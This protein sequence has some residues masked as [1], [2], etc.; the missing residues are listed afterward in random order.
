M[1]NVTVYR[2]QTVAWIYEYKSFQSI[3]LKWNTYREE[4]D[5]ISRIFYENSEVYSASLKSLGH[6]DAIKSVF[7]FIH[8]TPISCKAYPL[9]FNLRP[10]ADQH[11]KEFLKTWEVTKDSE[12]CWWMLTEIFEINPVF[13]TEQQ[14]RP[15]RK[16]KAATSLKTMQS[17]IQRRLS[18][19]NLISIYWIEH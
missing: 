5:R 3:N 15:R 18:K 6:G 10:I 12:K 14:I 17:P 4:T 13:P 2:P 16:K 11:I 8:S 9:P 19:W 7:R 1:T